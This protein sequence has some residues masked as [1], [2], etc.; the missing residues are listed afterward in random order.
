MKLTEMEILKF[1]N[2]Q[3]KH[4]RLEA[5][6]HHIRMQSQELKK[7]IEQRLD[8]SFDSHKINL[9]KGEVEEIQQ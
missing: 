4:E 3:M 2:L 6:M 9:A 8:I 5:Q 7:E 1:E